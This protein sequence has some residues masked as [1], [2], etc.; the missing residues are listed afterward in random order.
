MGNIHIIS[1][2]DIHM[3]AVS[4]EYCSTQRPQNFTTL[5]ASHIKKIERMQKK[6]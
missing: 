2:P 6:F 5:F 1:M 4:Q 3:Y